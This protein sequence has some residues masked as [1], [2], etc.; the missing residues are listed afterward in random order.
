M[1]LYVLQVIS[2]APD[3]LVLCAAHVKEVHFGLGIASQ[4]SVDTQ[5]APAH[6]MLFLLALNWRPAGHE[7]NELQ[8][9]LGSQHWVGSQFPPVHVLVSVVQL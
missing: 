7:A 6:V 2:A 8:V 4:H 3:L 5:V 1:Q 9:G